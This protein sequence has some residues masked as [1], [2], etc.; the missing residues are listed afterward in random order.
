MKIKIRTSFLAVFL[1]G[2]WASGE[3]LPFEVG[4]TIG[5]VPAR[6]D[7]MVIKS[8]L[9]KE[10]K[11]R[12]FFAEAKGGGSEWNCWYNLDLTQNLWIE[13]RGRKEERK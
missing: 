5:F 1:F 3:D 8:A 13:K 4:D 10:I 11:G 2:F 12:W 7:R 9:V 6:S